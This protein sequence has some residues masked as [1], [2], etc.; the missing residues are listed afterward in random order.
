MTSRHRPSR[1]ASLPALARPAAVPLQRRPVQ[2]W[3]SLGSQW[4]RSSPN[5]SASEATSHAHSK[6][7][8]HQKASIFLQKIQQRAPVDAKLGSLLLYLDDQTFKTEMG[9]IPER[10]QNIEEEVQVTLPKLFLT[11]N[12]AL[13]NKG[14]D[15]LQAIKTDNEHQHESEDP[16]I[17]LLHDMHPINRRRAAK[18]LCQM[19]ESEVHKF[20][21]YYQ[22]E[23][24]GN[25]M[26]EEGS[27]SGDSSASSSVD[28]P[29]MRLPQ[30][31]S[32][33]TECLN[34][35]EKLDKIEELSRKYYTAKSMMSTKKRGVLFQDTARPTDNEQTS[36]MESVVMKSSKSSEKLRRQDSMHSL[37]PGEFL[38]EA[39]LSMLLRTMDG[40]G[41]LDRLRKSLPDVVRLE[42]LSEEVK[43]AD[44]IQFLRSSLDITL[45]SPG[46]Q[47]KRTT[48]FN[49]YR[50]SFPDC[51]LE[52]VMA[53]YVLRRYP[54][55]STLQVVDLPD[56]PLGDSLCAFLCYTLAQYSESLSYLNLSYTSAAHKTAKALQ[57]L[58]KV[59]HSKLNTLRLA[60]NRLEDDGICSVVIGMLQ[61]EESAI[62]ALDVSCTSM[63]FTGALA[64]AKL[65]RINRTMKSLDL[66]E[67][68][69]DSHSLREL[70]RALIVNTTL[71][72]LSLRKCGLSDK[73]SRDLT[74]ALSNNQS[75]VQLHLSDNQFTVKLLKTIL[76]GL[77]ANRKLAHLGLSGNGA[78]VLEHLEEVKTELAQVKEVEIMKED[79]FV[80]SIEAKKLVAGL[81]PLK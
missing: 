64:L 14:Q 22:P 48:I 33:V 60:G 44:A 23:E 28:F 4:I 27:D 53:Y 71:S 76:P 10:L 2:P 19:I 61:A 38:R 47:T 45:R 31:K 66:G 8:Q 77:M 69:L 52:A 6:A 57:D 59:P 73:D 78:I 39:P 79:D 36:E 7:S 18:K 21:Q 68:K 30:L 17:V 12:E 70:C 11:M 54:A 65:L 62:V 75:L 13:S 3:T 16:K 29:H 50:V 51:K 35:R 43:H 55:Y 67:S 5:P 49:T 15:E 9:Q 40:G 25:L 56:N 26:M 81:Y 1:T 34:L 58:L 20:S 74:Q 37:D 63:E 80:K 24:N 46:K 72:S 32:K 42:R 41:F